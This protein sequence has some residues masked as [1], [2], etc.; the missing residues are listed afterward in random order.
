[1]PAFQELKLVPSRAGLYDYNVHDQ[2]LLLGALDD[3]QPN[4]AFCTGVERARA[5]ALPRPWQ[6][7]AV[8]EPVLLHGEFRALDLKRL[9]VDRVHTGVRVLERIIGCCA[10]WTA[11]LACL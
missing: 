10:T 5:A 9:S 1:M 6:G 8:A 7:R 3:G 11:C 4:V 2:N